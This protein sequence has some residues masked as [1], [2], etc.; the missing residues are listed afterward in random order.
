MKKSKEKFP[1]RFQLAIGQAFGRLTAQRVFRTRGTPSEIMFECSC[2]CG[3]KGV[4]RDARR[5]LR[6]KSEGKSSSCENCC[7]AFQEIRQ[8]EKRER[9]RRKASPGPPP[10]SKVAWNLSY[11]PFARGEVRG[12]DGTPFRDEPQL[13]PLSWG[14][15][16]EKWESSIR[17]SSSI[18]ARTS[19]RD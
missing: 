13:D 14:A 16:E 19:S 1:A 4:V 9:K 15:W 17:G 5:L 6:S 18:C 7:T 12:P 10:R 8:R 2:E 11:C 3:T